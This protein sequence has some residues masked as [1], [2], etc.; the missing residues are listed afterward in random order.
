M[1]RNVWPNEVER[2]QLRATKRVS[3]LDAEQYE[4]GFPPGKLPDFMAW[5]AEHINRIPEE[6]RASAEIEIDSRGSYEDS[7]YA[8]I[9]I[10]Y[11][12]PETDEEW[13]A[14]KA[15]VM[16]RVRQAEEQERKAYEALKAKFG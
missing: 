5:L 1:M 6:Y 16:S 3:V 4:D 10:S 15:N 12:R 9:K 14:R 13:D 11:V 7:H 2:L 8:T